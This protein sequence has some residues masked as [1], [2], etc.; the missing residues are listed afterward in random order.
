[1]SRNPAKL[2]GRNPEP[3][4]RTIRAYTLAELDALAAELSK[5]YQPLPAFAAATGLRPEEWAAL[6]RRD[7]DRRAGIL[8]VRRTVSDGVVVELAKTNASRRQVRFRVAPRPRSTCSRLGW[9]RRSCSR[10]PRAG[11]STS[12]TS[13][14]GSGAWRSRRPASPRPARI[15]DLRPTFAST[16]LA[17][18]VTVFEFARVMGTSVR[19]IERHYG[20]L[21]D[22]AASTPSTPSRAL[23]QA[24]KG[25]RPGTS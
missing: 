17:A 24:M 15:Y 11:C 8:T 21:L 10:R 1:M 5:P 12:T 2:A 19:M 9:I 18:R 22:G 23:R 14:A 6:E 3:P 20:A 25:E 4:P 7:L 13:A 16:A